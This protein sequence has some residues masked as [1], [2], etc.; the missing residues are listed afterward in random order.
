M[1]YDSEREAEFCCVAEARRYIADSAN[2]GSGATTYTDK[3]VS[4]GAVAEAAGC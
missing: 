4:R 2:T 3:T 1:V